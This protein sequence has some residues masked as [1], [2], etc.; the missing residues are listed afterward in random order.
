MTKQHRFAA[1]LKWSGGQRSPQVTYE[2]YS[3]D[4]TVETPG[5]PPL[6]GSGPAVFLG[7]EGRYN[8]EELLVVS[9]SACHML[10]YLA[11]CARA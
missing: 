8:P 3:R 4:Y 7:D 11:V 9:L 2:S 6:P 5:K 1:R 10:T